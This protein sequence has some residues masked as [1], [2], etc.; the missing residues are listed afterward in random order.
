[1]EQSD[2]MNTDYSYLEDTDLNDEDL[3][4]AVETILTRAAQSAAAEP[5]MGTSELQT[6]VSTTS[7]SAPGR[8]VPHTPFHEFLQQQQ[9]SNT[10]RKTTND[11]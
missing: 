3:Y 11:L 10:K 8:F 4:N 6:S 1:M 5:T 9:N 2:F 7:S